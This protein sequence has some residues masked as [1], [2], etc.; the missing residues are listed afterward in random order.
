MVTY[1][2]NRPQHR[3]GFSQTIPTHAPCDLRGNKESVLGS[4]VER[5]EPHLRA[6]TSDTNKDL[7]LSREGGRSQ[8]MHLQ[9]VSELTAIGS[10]RVD[11]RLREANGAGRQ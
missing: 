9:L 1:S 6:D 5:S 2:H 7:M 11:G 10:K 4:G 8:L 3:P